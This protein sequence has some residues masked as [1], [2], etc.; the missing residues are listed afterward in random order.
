M[1]DWKI[2]WDSSHP[3]NLSFFHPSILPFLDEHLIL[4]FNGVEQ[5]GSIV[6]CRSY[7]LGL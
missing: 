1:E 5:N 7:R 3:S 6:F 2:G 4:A